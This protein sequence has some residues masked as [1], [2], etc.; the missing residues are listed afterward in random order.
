MLAGILVDSMALE[1][2][3]WDAVTLSKG[4]ISSLARIHRAADTADVMSGAGAAMAAG[5]LHDAA[6]QLAREP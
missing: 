5:I 3:G 6:I 1:A 4:S 2:R